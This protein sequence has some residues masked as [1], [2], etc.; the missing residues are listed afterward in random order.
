M[1]EAYLTLAPDSYVVEFPAGATHAS[2]A[3]AVRYSNACTDA[4]ASSLAP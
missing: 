1:G 2:P 4:L 3:R